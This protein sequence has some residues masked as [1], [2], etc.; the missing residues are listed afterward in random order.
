[1]NSKGCDSI[2]HLNLSL[3]PE[4]LLSAKAILQGPYD[5]GLGLMYDSLR[6]QGIIP[7]TEP[8]SLLPYNKPAIGEPGGETITNPTVL[9]DHGNNS[10]VD[11]VYLEL[12]SASNPSTIVA[13]KRAL[14]QRDGDIV[15][16]V[17]GIS[18]VHF[19]NTPTGNYYIS[20]KHRNHLG[21][22]S[23]SPLTL[24]Q[25]VNASID[26]STLAPV[27]TISSI[28]NAP[29]KV[30]GSSSLLWTGDVNLNKNVKYNGLS[31]DKDMI[32]AA[33]G[34]LAFINNIV[35]GYRAEDVNMD[36]KIK[37]NNLDNDRAVILN[38]VGV[39]TPNTIL[40][41]HTPN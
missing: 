34:G 12:R 28:A 22:M 37:Y 36:G 19:L 33:V 17:D 5:A 41:Q 38:N 35:Y 10:I 30:I 20:V 39:N 9:A 7:T 15:S 40:S 21:V 25:C 1:V 4:V 24:T 3:T 32:N 26:F 14:L 31:N 6:V 16:H 23:A 13:T 2:T 29:R 27:Y 8:Y 18:P 11:W